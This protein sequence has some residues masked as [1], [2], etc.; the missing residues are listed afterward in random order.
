MVTSVTKKEEK[1]ADLIMDSSKVKFT[2][3][4]TTFVDGKEKIPAVRYEVML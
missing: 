4:K 2:K 1:N 3:I